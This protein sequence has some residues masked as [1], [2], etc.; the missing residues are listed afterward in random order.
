[1]ETVDIFCFSRQWTQLVCRSQVLLS[2]L[3]IV[4]LMSVPF[5]KPLPF[6]SDI[7]RVHNIQ[8]PVWDLYLSLIVK[9]FIALLIPDPFTLKLDSESRSS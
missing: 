6:Y 4:V 1:M 5:S 7:C 2:L 8:W 3:W 9:V